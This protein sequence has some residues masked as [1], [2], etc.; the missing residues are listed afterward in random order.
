MSL[1][2]D[3]KNRFLRKEVKEKPLPKNLLFGQM[4]SSGTNNTSGFISE[5]FNSIFN[6]MSAIDTYDEM[7]KTD[8]TIYATIRALKLPIL[9]AERTVQPASEDDA[10]VQ[11]AQFV[12]DNI[13]QIDGGFDNFLNEAL[14]Y[15]TF[16]FYY[17]EKVYKV[18]DGEVWIKK[19]APRQP[20]AHFRWTMKTTPEIPGITQ[21]IPTATPE[22]MRNNEFNL[23]PEIPMSKLV[24]FTYDK[25]GDNHAG[26]SIIRSA[27]IHWYHKNNLYRLDGIK[28]ERGA[29]ILKIKMPDSSSEKDKDLAKEMGRNFKINESSY[30]I[31]PGEGWDVDMITSG[32]SDQSSS[33]DTSIQHHNTQIAL[34]ILAQFLTLGSGSTGSFALSKD[35]S[36][37]F[38]LG[39]R[40]IANYMAN[41][42]NESLVKEL[43]NLNFGPQ[44]KYPKLVFG[45]IGKIETQETANALKVL[46]ESGLIKPDAK[47]EVWVRKTFGLPEKTLEEIIE[48]Q[49]E[50]DSTSS[51]N[52]KNDV[53]NGDLGSEDIQKTAFNGA[54]IGAAIDIVERISTGVLRRESGIN[55]LTTFFPLSKQQAINLLVGVETGEIEP[56]QATPDVQVD[57]DEEDE[58][59]E[60]EKDEGQFAEV[61]KKFRPF[62]QLTL[63]E[64]RV[65]FAELKDFFDGTDDEINK[66]L[67]ALT[68]RQKN[69][70]LQQLTDA[71]ENGDVRK[72]Q[73][74]LLPFNTELT[75]QLK[76][77][78]KKA[79]EQGK[80]DAAREMKVSV[81]ETS[82][83]DIALRNARIQQAVQDRT[84]SIE[85]SIKNKALDLA[86]KGVGDASASFALEQAF[87]KAAIVENNQISGRTIAQNINIGRSVVFDKNKEDIFA[88]QRSEIL[89]E[90]T[91]SMC[92]SLDG[93]VINKNDPFGKI[94]QVHSNCRGI[95]VVILPTDA[96]LPTP[97]PIPKS[98]QNRFDT[99]E[100]VPT[101]NA[102]KQL[103]KPLIN[104]TSRVAEAADKLNN[105][106]LQK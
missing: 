51:N 87:D 93:R 48:E 76:E 83:K 70:I 69:R 44:E 97:K 81:P 94:D 90:K 22:D 46:I 25:E 5:D 95:W 27:Y 78:A 85:S 10:D 101:T 8:A 40:Q 99:V 73:N 9:A 63:A 100:G 62:R 79:F 75:K 50:Q 35:Q 89:D 105:P 7:R 24:L 14:N 103:K 34:N 53:G 12:E 52:G 59:D 42:L 65:K 67:T 106:N 17:F 15:L 80:K 18:K 77:S 3:F 21:Q 104:K 36:G 23:N 47:M 29:G 74:I 55:F 4:G 96:D 54:Q 98:I 6:E 91:C 30:V 56:E 43:V 39:L 26:F 82:S 84:R 28:A 33:I 86:R 102:F 61:K 19:L 45:N 57:I 37:F 60:E 66:A 72:I 58:E 20:S 88:L 92:L 31:L 68:L 38:L 41:I 16:G 11:I 13:K 71:V 64:E 1:V 32:I 49:E 2:S